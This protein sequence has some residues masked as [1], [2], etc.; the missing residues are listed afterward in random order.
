[1]PRRDAVDR[2]PGA[3]PEPGAATVGQ[4]RDGIAAAIELAGQRRGREH[5]TAGAAG[6][7]NDGAPAHGRS[8]PMRRLVRASSN[9]M[10][11]ATAISDDPP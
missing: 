4:Q 9:P 3:V 10:A 1:M 7:E 8:S 6:G 5:V 2:G 11:S